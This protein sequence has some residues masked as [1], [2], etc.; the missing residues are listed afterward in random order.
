M[1]ETQPLRFSPFGEA[2]IHCD[3]AG[4]KLDHAVQERIWSLAALAAGW[5]HVREAVPG[6]NNL[7]LVYD[8]ERADFEVM[9]AAVEEAW[10]TLDVSRRQGR[11]VEIPVCYGG[12]AGVDLEEVARHAG[13]SVEAVA[14]RHAASECTVYCLGSQPGFAYLAGMDERLATPRRDVPRT[15]VEAGSVVIGGAQTG[16]ISCDSPSGWHIIGRTEIRLFDP[17]REAP[18]LLSPGDRIRFR[19]QEVR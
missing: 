12:E 2:A 8:P 15:R 19:I 7:L 14:Q 10:S 5:P 6:M 17:D 3:A 18:I 4:E 16:V 1:H 13:L 9:R 11:V